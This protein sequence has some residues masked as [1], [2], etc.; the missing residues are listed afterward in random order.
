MSPAQVRSPTGQR[1]SIDPR[2]RQRRIDVARRR[3][4]RRLR[5]VLAATVV[6]VLVV[7]GLAVLHTPWFSVRTI[8]VEGS[9]PHTTTAAIVAAAGLG[10][11]PPLVSVNPGATAA[12]IEALPFVASAVVGREWPDHVVIT[13]EERAP[14]VQMAGPGPRWSILD[15]AGRTLVT[16]PGRTPRLAVLVVHAPWGP[17]PPA[18]IGG[19][20][21]PVAGPGLAVARTLP[22]AFAAQVVSVTVAP[23]RT[24]SLAL[25]SGIVVQLGTATELHAKYEDVAAIIAHASL[26]GATAIDVSVPQSPTVTG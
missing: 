20:L 17:I 15:G 12:R 2:I 5:W 23:D 8:T 13:V 7:V 18:A 24:V 22:A 9:H 16:G 3:G 11:H 14:A 21:P 1:R 6:V 26:R 19:S 4:R 10:G 25:D